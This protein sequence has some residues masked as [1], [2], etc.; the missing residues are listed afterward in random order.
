[1]RIARCLTVALSVALTASAAYAEHIDLW[2]THR[3]AN[4]PTSDKRIGNEVLY[5]VFLDRFANG[6]TAN[7]CLH[8]ARYCDSGKRDWYRYWGGD[9]RGLIQKMPY[10]K[11]LGVTRLWIT[12]IF[13]NQHVTV[14][15]SRLGLGSAEVTSYHG[16][17]IRDWFRLNEF[18]TDAGT[19]DFRIVD[20]LI[21]SAQPEI[22]ILLDSVTN[23]TSPADASR[24]SLDYVTRQEPLDQRDGVR[25]THRGALFRDGVYVTS[26]DEDEQ[27][28]GARIPEYARRFHPYGPIRDYNDLFQVENFQLDGLADL[29]QSSPEV[30][31]YLRDAHQF[32]LERYPGLA[33][34]RMDTIKHVDHRYWTMFDR[35]LSEAFPEA[36]V[37]GE[38]FGGGFS[39]AGA[40]Q[41]YR[42]TS[43]SMFDFEFRY[44]VEGVYLRDQPVTTFTRL[45]ANDPQLG[46]G[47][48]LVTFLDNH[49]LQRLRGMGMS[50]EAMKQATALMFASRGIPSVYYG[51]EQ[52]LFHPN[53]PGDPY[54]R[55]MMRSWDRDAELF[56]L[57]KTMSALRKRNPALRYG[58]THVVHESQR[59]LAFE[60]TL[61]GSTKKVFFAMSTN[62]ITGSDDFTMQGL[63]LPNGVYRDLL[64][65][66]GYEVRNGKVAVQLRR[67]DVI[68]L[69]AQ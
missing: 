40:R 8:E 37:V 39:S 33:G 25:R 34:F 46:D 53:D 44:T 47:R 42:E 21:D 19:Q 32:W 35:D 61:D 66:R 18:F 67:Y 2:L 50:P 62:P 69:E 60:R 45:W 13:Q 9:I 31:A 16:Y 12:P 27:R 38:Y 65:G 29:D 20:E 43:M 1:M 17:W 55:P 11:D 64:S 51:L 52:D 5:Q 28:A 24:A 15:R 68:V 56:K 58:K 22:K 10:L 63:T 26:L 3:A 57:V 7:D 4:T 59:I 49:D 30:Y 36:E 54:N 48:G 41:Y 6:N 23:H 14:S